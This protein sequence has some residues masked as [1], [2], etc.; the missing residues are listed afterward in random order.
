MRTKVLLIVAVIA[1]ATPAMAAFSGGTFYWK[2]SGGTYHQFYAGSKAQLPQDSPSTTGGPF[3]VLF[4]G[5][6]ALPGYASAAVGDELFKTWCVERHITF[7]PGSTYWVTVDPYAYSGGGGGTAT[8]MDPI[9][10]VTRGIYEVWRAGG[11]TW[12]LA[13]IRDAIWYAEEEGGSMTAEIKTA[14]ETY[15]GDSLPAD[16]ADFDLMAG[17][18]DA[19]NLWGGFAKETV[20]GLGE[21]WVAKDKQSHIYI[22]PVPGAALLGVLGLG[23]VSRLRRRFA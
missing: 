19:L 9:S 12:T 14:V 11:G 23:L 3:R 17:G 22:V 20:D 5:G 15:L 6:A 2:D 7:N 1:I 18:L 16:P 8:G 4:K 10:E 21:V 13:D